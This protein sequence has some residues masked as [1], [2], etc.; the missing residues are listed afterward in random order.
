MY[1]TDGSVDPTSRTAGAA[2]VHEEATGL[3]RVPNGA[4]TLQT[5]LVAIL[6]ALQYAED[7]ENNILIHADSLGAIQAIQHHPPDN[8]GLITN[9]LATGQRIKENGRQVTINWIPSHTGISGNEA[10]DEAA[11]EALHLPN[12]NAHIP[13]SLSSIKK[14]IQKYIH[15][16]PRQELQSWASNGSP[17]AAWHLTVLERT[18]ALP[19]NLPRKIRTALHRIRMG[20]RCRIQLENAEQ[21]E[22]QCTHCQAT[23][24]SPLQHY[25]L[26]CPATRR[27]LN[28]NHDTAPL[29]VANTDL[30][31]LCQLVSS[32]PPP[33]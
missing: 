11:K 7:R 33:R 13:P 23:T 18:P 19:T 16:A 6:K 9:I 1:F 5:E 17:S 14:G 22:E 30:K 3:Y 32:F 24:A 26:E 28:R 4:S 25:I 21:H 2:F 27:H 29:V 8:V 10:A 20:Y 12:I 31:E 15:A